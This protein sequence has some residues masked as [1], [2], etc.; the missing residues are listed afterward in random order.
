MLIGRMIQHQIDDHAH[1]ALVGLIEQPPEHPRWCRTK[2]QCWEIRHIITIIAQRRRIKRQQPEAI[3]AQPLE[4][5]EL[6]DQ[7]GEIP[8]AVVV[9]VEEGADVQLVKH[10]VLVPEGILVQHRLDLADSRP[11]IRRTP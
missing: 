8:D 2:A 11:G 4:I 5:I 6:L 9:A 3:H 10:G 1:A 7:A